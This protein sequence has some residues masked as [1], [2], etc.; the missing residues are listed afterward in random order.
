[1]EGDTIAAIATAPGPAGLAVVRVSGSA[2]ASIAEQVIRRKPRPRHATYSTFWDTKGRPIDQGV[3][4][5]FP[6][7]HSYTGESVLELQGHGG[8][9]VPALIME[10]V[11]AL[12]ARIA[13]PGEFSERAFRNNKLDLAQAEAVGDLIYSSSQAA[14]R[15]AMQSLC[16]G[17]S[18]RIHQLVGEILRLRTLVEA[19]LDFPDEEIDFHPPQTEMESLRQGLLALIEQAQQGRLLRDG[20]QVVLAGPPNVGKSSLMNYLTDEPTSIV[21]SAPGTTRDVIQTQAV[22]GGL[23]MNL[24]DTAGFREKPSEEVEA[25]GMARAEKQ[26][27]TADLIVWVTAVETPND[28]PFPTVESGQKLLRVHNKIDLT[29]ECPPGI[30]SDG[31]AYVS[32]LKG[33][34]LGELKQAMLEALGA[35]AGFEGSFTARQRH[36]ESLNRA[37]GCVVDGGARVEMLELLAEHLRGA[38]TALG[39]ITGEVSTEDLLGQIFSS[40]CIGK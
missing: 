31:R 19:H 8:N 33:Q 3:A 35:S 1:M 17:F 28:H 20:A 27:K 6:A 32:V 40:F 24:S 11:T 15:A 16:G 7:P 18:K 13:R 5:Y 34:G 26:L 29:R 12:G 21:A 23:R 39:E 9:M 30:H 22:I 36:L 14:A 4:L 2:A 25:V 38:Q 37:L 10:T